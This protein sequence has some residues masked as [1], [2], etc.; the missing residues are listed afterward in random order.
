VWSIPD[1][2]A[3]STDAAGPSSITPP[4]AGLPGELLFDSDRNNLQWDIFRMHADGT[5]VEPVVSGPSDERE[6][7]LSSDGTRLAFV[8]NASGSYQIVIRD[9]LTGVD[10]TVTS[11]PSGA[12]QPSWSSNGQRLVFTTDEFAHPVE[13]GRVYTV[14]ARAGAQPQLLLDLAANTTGFGWHVPVFAPGDASIMV[15]NGMSL[16]EVFLVGRS[17]RQIVPPTGRIPNPDQAA[18][19][20]DGTL[21]VLQDHCGLQY[22]E[23]Y[24]VRFDGRTGDT[25]ANGRQLTSVDFVP[26]HPSWSPSNLIAFH[27]RGASSDIYIV[28]LGDGTSTPVVYNLTHSVANERNPVWIP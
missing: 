11:I 6:P 19:S 8:T 5:G 2:G 26:S 28:A 18:L 20:P 7:A 9:L 10:T 3:P 17:T 23:L 24:I 27:S 1:S 21:V 4:P 12:R 25:C 13:G 22:Q 15:G 14:E 16:V